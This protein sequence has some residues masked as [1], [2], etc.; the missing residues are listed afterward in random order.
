MSKEETPEEE[1][2]RL[3]IEF[4]SCFVLDER[5]ERLGRDITTLAEQFE[6][7]MAAPEEEIVEDAPMSPKS[8]MSS[9]EEEWVVGLS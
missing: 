7:M 9:D 3:L 6:K 1:F 5:G 4:A 2:E 8:P